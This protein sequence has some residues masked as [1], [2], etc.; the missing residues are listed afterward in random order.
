MPDNNWGW[1]ATSLQVL[2]LA[3]NPPKNMD[4]KT[5]VDGEF[6]V[7]KMLA[8]CRSFQ[9]GDLYDIRND[10]IIDRGIFKIHFVWHRLGEIR[11]P[12]KS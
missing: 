1:N 12:Y 8:L 6:Q 11:V 5:I 10:L 2:L 9:L 4:E 3:L 7:I